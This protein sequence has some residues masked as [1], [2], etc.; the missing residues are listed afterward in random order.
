M[1]NG[2]YM[3]FS[4]FCADDNKPIWMHAEEREESK[5]SDLDWPFI[6]F[7]NAIG[8]QAAI[9]EMDWTSKLEWWRTADYTND[10]EI[11]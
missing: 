6:N 9:M 11:F 8:W 10:K 4:F 1:W 7:I 3:I 5:V 2:I